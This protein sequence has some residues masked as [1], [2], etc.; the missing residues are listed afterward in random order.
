[1]QIKSHFFAIFLR[2]N[3][4]IH[5]GG[6]RENLN[7]TLAHTASYH[8]YESE[9]DVNAKV[10]FGAKTISPFK[11]EKEETVFTL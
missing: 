7:P 10:D 11:A 3:I 8:R 2:K 1:M 5:L 9:R 4:L 6:G